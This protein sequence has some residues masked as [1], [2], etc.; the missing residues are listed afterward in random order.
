M[1]PIAILALFL[2]LASPGPP[3]PAAGHFVSQTDTAIARIRREYAAVNV[4]LPRC[5]K[6]TQD[7][8]G[9]STEGGSLE[10]Y[11]CGGEIRVAT[12]YGE[13]GQARSEWYL[14][15]ERPFF[16]FRVDLR[17]ARQFGPVASRSEE[18]VYLRDGQIIR[19]TGRDRD[20]AEPGDVR[21]RADEA[22]R[23]IA[24]LLDRA[25]TGRVD[26]S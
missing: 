13:T 9:Q 3:P 19:W 2:G 1:V 26:E 15:G 10:V 20:R 11:R 8:F 18:R 16:Q 14:S 22:A 23:E 17:Y 7:L 5:I 24:D 4:M 21:T 12:Y 6:R 25:R